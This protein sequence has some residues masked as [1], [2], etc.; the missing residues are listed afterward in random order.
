MS[1]DVAA[2]PALAIVNPSDV[3]QIFGGA[4]GTAGESPERALRLDLHGMRV[5]P[6]SAV[7]AGTAI[8]GAWSAAAH[9]VVGMRL[10]L[11][12]DAPCPG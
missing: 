7:T 4:T 5:Y 1:S 6:S 11:L 2:E 9:F 10:T 12:V 8:V 3:V